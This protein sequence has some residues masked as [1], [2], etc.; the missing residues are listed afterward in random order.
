MIT[1][2]GLTGQSGSG[3]SFL[4]GRFSERGIPVIDADTVSHQVTGCNP[5][6]LR[7]LRAAFGNDVF[8]PDGTLNRKKLGAVVFSDPAKLERLNQTVFPFITREIDRMIAAEETAG[9]RLLL[10]DAP[11]LY[12]AGAD[13]FCRYVVAVCAP[14]EFRLRRIMERDSLTREGALLRIS[15]QKDEA[16]YADRANL[17]LHNDGTKEEFLRKAEELI[18]LLTRRFL[19]PE[20]K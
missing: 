11:T 14:L 2:I 18:A 6:C 15:A 1:V 9:N 16:Y 5:G 20:I 12:E 10:L 7:A 17:V 8:E 4:S 19:T 3:K 13:K